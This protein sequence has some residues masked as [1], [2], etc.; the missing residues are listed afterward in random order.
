MI[1]AEVH[2]YECDH[3]S[4]PWVGMLHGPPSVTGDEM[5]AAMDDA[6]RRPGRTVLAMIR[7][8]LDASTR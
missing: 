1:D 7:A 2:A 4:R 5:V 6:R 8:A 3:P